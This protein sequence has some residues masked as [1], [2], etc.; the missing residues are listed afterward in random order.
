MKYE[1]IIAK[2]EHLPFKLEFGNL[3]HIQFV[4][5]VRELKDSYSKLVKSKA[6]NKKIMINKVDGLIKTVSDFI[7]FLEKKDESK[8]P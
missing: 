2:L 7:K 5:S 4:E 1:E 3:T 8:T 6:K